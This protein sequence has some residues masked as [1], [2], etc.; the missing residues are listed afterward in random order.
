M[1]KGLTLFILALF[2][3]SVILSCASGPQPIDY[4]ADE[5]HR[6]KMIIS[7]KQF[8]AEL[9]TMKGRVYKYD[10][11]ECLIPEVLEKGVDHYSHMLV[12]DY[13]APGQ[14]IEASSAGYLISK[15][16]PSPMGAYL[17]AYA[18]SDKAKI[19]G[20]KNQGE[21][22]DWNSILSNFKEGMTSIQ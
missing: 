15:E 16:R 14:F 22:F 7:Q 10:A 18:T 12:T 17:S 11:I 1:R 3:L 9:I 8:G 4:N 20:Q 5:C 21:I 2:G 6:C 19:A 13:D